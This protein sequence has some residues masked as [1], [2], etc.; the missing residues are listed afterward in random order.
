MAAI[1][2]NRHG[3]R[4][5]PL[6]GR[7][8]MMWQRCT[9]PKQARYKDYGAK[10]ISVCDEWKN[11]AVFLKDMGEPPVGASIERIDNSKGY[12]PG[13]CI[14]ATNEVQMRNTSRTRI[15]EFNGKKQC[16]ADWAKELGLNEASLRERL[17]KWTIEKSLTQPKRK[18][19]DS[20]TV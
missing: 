1:K 8:L 11:F 6:Y 12:S 20:A 7:W 5:H 17:T 4:Y 13:N 14:W 19:N 16:V 2:Q 18:K 10:G 15:I 9:N 3:L